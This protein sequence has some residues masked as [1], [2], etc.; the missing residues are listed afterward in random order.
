MNKSY[1]IFMSFLQT[2]KFWLNMKLHMQNILTQTKTRIGRDTFV[3][4]IQLSNLLVG[5]ADIG[6]SLR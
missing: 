6:I 5:L 1:K 2:W 4:Y 3:A